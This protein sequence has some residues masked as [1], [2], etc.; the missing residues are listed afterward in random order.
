LLFPGDTMAGSP[1]TPVMVP[2]VDAP[3]AKG[4]A[5]AAS[6]AVAPADAIAFMAARRVILP[7]NGSVLIDMVPSSTLRLE[8]VP[9]PDLHRRLRL[10]LRATT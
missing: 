9:E 8:Q 3:F 1:S 2:T 7:L 6:A 4:E 10:R 5:E